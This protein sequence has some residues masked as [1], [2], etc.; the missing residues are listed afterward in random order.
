MNCCGTLWLADQISVLLKQEEYMPHLNA[1]LN[2]GAPAQGL[3]CISA[4]V[5]ESSTNSQGSFLEDEEK[6]E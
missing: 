4:T 2:D 3:E 1:I 5:N 6:D